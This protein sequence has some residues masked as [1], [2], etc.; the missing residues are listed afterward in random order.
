MFL[1]EFTHAIDDKNRVVIPAKFRTFITDAQ[2]REGFFIIVSPNPEERCLRLFTMSGWRKVSERL[3]DEAGKS[4][5][6]AS[7]MRFFA[8]R[9]EFCPMDSQSRLLIPQK[10]LDY[11]GLKREV[12][13]IGNFDWIEIW[14][15]DEYKSETERLKGAPVDRKRALWPGK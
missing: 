12:I 6:P 8:S 2:D 9:G 10:L 13:M 3:R 14:N 1:G 5:D 15:E 7:T 11:A 4:E